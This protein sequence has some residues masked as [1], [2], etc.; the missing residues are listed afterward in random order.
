MYR[1]WAFTVLFAL[2]AGFAFAGGSA[3]V[4]GSCFSHSA[5]FGSRADLHIGPRH[6]PDLSPPLK[7]VPDMLF[8]PVVPALRGDIRYVTP[9]AGEKVVALTFDMCELSTKTAGYDYK[10]VNAL[11]RHSARATFFA[12][13][14]WM[15]SHPE[16]AKQL[17]ADPLFEVGSHTWTHGNFGVM[18]DAAMRRQIEWTQAE[19]EL[20]RG[21]LLSSKCAENIPRAEKDK[22]PEVP[23]VF[24]LPYGRC[25][26]AALDLVNG[27]GLK[28]IQ[29]NVSDIRLEGEHPPE[30]YA[31]R[32]AKEI[33]P[34]SIV[35]MH[36]NG[37]VKETG[38][39]VEHLL[40]LLEAEG[41]SF[42]TVSELLKRGEVHSEYECY[43]EKEGDN[44]FLDKIYG[45]GTVHPVNKKP[46]L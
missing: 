1:I 41:Y 27:Y 22:I 24:R 46:G 19:Y 11:R 20:L 33:K 5:L 14:K 34:G 40:R 7:T 44:L 26:P 30:Y 25:T 32:L 39:V 43:F 21:E 37:V 35:L 9:A 29:W 31:E 38:D 15:R 12:G 45:D 23:E 4:L 8:P 2:T 13:G 42:L 28:V 6:E 3:A 16:K 17:I 18:S 10:A 36:A